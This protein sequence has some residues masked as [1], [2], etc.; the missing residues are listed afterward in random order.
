[1]PTFWSMRCCSK[2]R[3]KTILAAP[4]SLLVLLLS[5]QPLRAVITVSSPIFH[6][7]LKAASEA[8]GS[9]QSLVLIVFGADWCAPC[10]QLKTKTLDSQ[11]FKEQGGALHVAEVDVDSESNM[12]RDYNVEAVPTLVLLTPDNKIVARQIGRATGR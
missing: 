10:K 4:A 9:D 8:A 3:L 12:A 2:L 5:M 11:E 1:M 6:S 7:S